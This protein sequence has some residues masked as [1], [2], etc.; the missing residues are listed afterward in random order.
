MSHS[1]VF[2][3]I[4]QILPGEVGLWVKCNWYSGGNKLILLILDCL[5]LH[6]LLIQ[7][8]IGYQVCTKLKCSGWGGGGEKYICIQGVER[9]ILLDFCV[10]V[11]TE[12]MAPYSISLIGIS[13]FQLLLQNSTVRL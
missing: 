5:F 9:P 11:H 1:S 4:G 10:P 6:R 3:A 2:S 12:W 8:I 7:N 13:I